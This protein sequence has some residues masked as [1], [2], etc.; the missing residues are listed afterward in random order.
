MFVDFLYTVVIYFF[1]LPGLIMEWIVGSL[2][3]TEFTP[4]PW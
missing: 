3:S 4:D 1:A 2:G